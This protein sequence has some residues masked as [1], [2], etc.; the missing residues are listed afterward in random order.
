MLNLL[1]LDKRNSPFILPFMDSSIALLKKLSEAHG[2]SGFEYEV[3]KIAK[4]ELTDFG[5]ISTDKLG[6]L[7]C[8]VGDAGPKVMIAAHMDEIGFMV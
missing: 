6:S 1:L 5:T 3:R 4:D 2:V 8:E 7:V